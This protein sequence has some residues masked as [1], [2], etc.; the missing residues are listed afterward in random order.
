MKKIELL[1][2]NHSAYAYVCSVAQRVYHERLSVTIVHFPRTIFAVFDEHEC[3][4]AMGLHSELTA[5]MF[6]HD[7]RVRTVLAQNTSMRVSEQ[8]IFFT[9]GCPAAVPLLIATV[10]EYAQYTGFTHVIY[11]AIAVSARTIRHLGYT[12]EDLGPVDLETFPSN[13]RHN[14]VRW[15]TEYDPRICLLDTTDARKRTEAIP[16]LLA[17]RISLAPELQEYIAAMRA[18]SVLPVAA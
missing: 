16:H 2:P 4:A 6:K 11:A 9:L 10:A 8:G 12:V 7:Q 17:R 1:T 15:H 5:D 3:I 13:E 18:K 14:Y